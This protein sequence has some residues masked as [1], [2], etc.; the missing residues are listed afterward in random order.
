MTEKILCSNLTCSNMILPSTAEQ[1][2]GICMPCAQA[3]ARKERDEYILKNR[4]DINEFTDVT[5]PVELLKI[6]HRPRKFDPLINWIPC[7]TPTE[8]IYTQL[9]S[10]E[11]QR[12]AN[13]A[14][15]L[16]GTPRNNEAEEI[17]LCLVA[18]T[19]ASV[20]NC[21]QAFLAHDLYWPSF[22]FCRASA[23]SRDDL[24]SRLDQVEEE[25]NQILLILAWIG[26]VVVVEL[27]DRWRKHPPSWINSLHVAPQEYSKEAGWELTDDGQRRDLFFHSCTKLLRGNSQSPQRFRSIQQR[28]DSCP[29]CNQKLTN[30]L[31]LMPSEFG[32]SNI[33]D[34]VD[35]IQVATCEV[36]TAFGYV[37]GVCDE[38][39]RS[40]WSI[41]NTKPR[42]LPNDLKDWER[43]PSNSLNFGDQRSH[44]FAVD[45]SLPTTFSQI[46]G[47]PTWIQDANYPSCPECQKTMMF[48]AQLDHADIEDFT[49]G[50]YYAFVCLTCR[51]TATSYQQT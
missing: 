34:G 15:L 47:H 25:R 27:F 23:E 30:L 17:V 45:P 42:H 20:E 37:F 48:L 24:I 33:K 18:F 41:F 16:I 19:N 38:S 43:I 36:C 31:D 29:W 7:L 22:S 21:L 35:R 9:N 32:I 39:G 3:K 46:G 1:N 50:M 8:Q 40:Q 26:D 49:E 6:I 2:N 5:D 11:Q 10:A 51:T 14:E 44:L 13:Y 28:D 4:R 12:L